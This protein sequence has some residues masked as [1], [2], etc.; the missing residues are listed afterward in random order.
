MA[1]FSKLRIGLAG[2][3]SA[4]VNETNL[5]TTVGSGAAPVF[6]TPMLIALMEAASVNC[7]EGLLPDE[8]QS[9]GVH[10]DVRHTSPTPAGLT[11]TATAVL[12]SVE[13][14]KLNFDVVAHD[15][16]EQIGSGQHTRVIVPSKSFLERVAAKSPPRV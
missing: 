4:E 7:V 13:G 2:S 3:A 5:A 12:K 1:D 11:V 10:V 9:L 8:H 14:R 15:G 6:A 16:H